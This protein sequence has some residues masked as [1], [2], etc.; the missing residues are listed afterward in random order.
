MYMYEEKLSGM[1]ISTKSVVDDLS[2]HEWI[3]QAPKEILF[4]FSKWP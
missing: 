3:P 1:N 2:T 4:W